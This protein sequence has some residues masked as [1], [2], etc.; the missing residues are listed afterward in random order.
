MTEQLHLI[1]L[2]CICVLKKVATE[3][4]VSSPGVFKEN[5]SQN[6]M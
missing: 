1:A 5:T 3:C 4:K 2:V 6:V